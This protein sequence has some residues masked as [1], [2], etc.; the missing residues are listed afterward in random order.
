M[1]YIPLRPTRFYCQT[2][3]QTYALPQGGAIKAYKEL[4]C[5][6]D[7]YELVLFTLGSGKLP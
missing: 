4:H 7:G 3:E 1:Q 5:P 6:L 2:C